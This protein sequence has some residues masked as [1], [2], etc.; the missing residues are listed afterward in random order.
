M[1]HLKLKLNEKELHKIVLSYF[2]KNRQKKTYEAYFTYYD[3]RKN[4]IVVKSIDITDKIHFEEGLK[5]SL[6]SL[7]EILSKSPSMICNVDQDGQILF[8]NPAFLNRLDFAEEELLLKSF[9]DLI[10]KSYLENNIFDFR[11]FIGED[12]KQIDL[13]IITKGGKCNFT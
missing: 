11:S 9:Y 7:R 8:A 12:P 13:P 5:L 1:I 10:D 2:D 6:K 3:K 4:R